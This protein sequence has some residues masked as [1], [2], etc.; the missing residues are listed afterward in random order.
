MLV[1]LTLTPPIFLRLPPTIQEMFLQFIVERAHE[2]TR[3]GKRKTIQ[4]RDIGGSGC[5]S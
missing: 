3:N 5:R 2:Q 4:S 1:V